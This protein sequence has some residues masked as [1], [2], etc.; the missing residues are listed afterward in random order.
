[1]TIVVTGA[2]GFIGRHLVTELAGT[3]ATVVAIDRR[4]MP[5]LPPSAVPLRADLLDDAAADAIRD[6]SVVFH[7]AARP[8]VRERGPEVERERHRDNVLATAAVLSAAT[9]QTAVV[10]TSSSSVYGGSFSRACAEGD[11]LLPRGGYARSKVAVE[12]LCADRL[13]AGGAAAVARPFTVV[14]EGQRP[15]MAIAMWIDAVRR[16]DRVQL[17]GGP[18]RSRDVTDVH[19]VVRSLIELADRGLGRTVNIGTGVGHSLAALLDAVCAAVG[20]PAQVESAPACVDDV[21]ATLAD[22]SRFEALL[23]WRP[24]TDLAELVRRQAD[25]SSAADAVLAV[26][27]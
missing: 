16:G 20:R 19:D 14:G 8:G 17:F 7:L 11:V 9:P 3:G 23:G 21:P 25:A 13:A 18:Q 5:D 27:G 24:V 10:V 2:A 12:Q 15:D 4:P 6:A 22:T 26:P 1:M